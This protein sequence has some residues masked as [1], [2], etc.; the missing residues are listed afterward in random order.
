[1]L[2]SFTK[3]T[4]QKFLRRTGYAIVRRQTFDLMLA[5]QHQEIVIR[6]GDKLSIVPTGTLDMLVRESRLLREQAGQIARLRREVN[7]LQ[8]GQSS[9]AAA[10]ASSGSDQTADKG[11]LYVPVFHFDGLSTDPNNIHNHDFLKNPR[12]IAA[13]QRAIQAVGVDYKY[14]WRVHVALW[15]ASLALS[16]P[17]DFVECGVWRGLLSTAIMHYYDWNKLNRR[18]VLFDTFKGFDEKQV[19]DE[20][21][22]KGNIAHFRD[23]YQTDVYDDVVR[24]FS[25][26]G[27]VEIVRGPVPD[28]L[29]TKKIDR[30][31]YLS[32]DMNNAAPEIAAGHYFWDRL[33]PGA[34]ILLDDYGFVT[35]EVQKRAWDQFA[36]EHGTS[37][38]A[39]PTGQGL[40]LKPHS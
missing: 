3:T 18:F 33:V 28:T 4:L 6:D 12:F 17:G 26:F 21:I 1:M 22:L 38:L 9:D 5:A 40:I 2:S 11:V 16:L 10:A 23:H 30:V 20:E 34:P 15:C 14:Y 32:I 39:L 19:S 7:I 35:Y 37:V 13:Y 8:A 25:D 24:N 29:P 36:T 27:N 31:C